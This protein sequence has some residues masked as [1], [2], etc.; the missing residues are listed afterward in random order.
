VRRA[1]SASVPCHTSV[2]PPIPSSY[3]EPIERNIHL[4]SMG[5]Q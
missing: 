3:G 2:F 4:F 5:M 1:I